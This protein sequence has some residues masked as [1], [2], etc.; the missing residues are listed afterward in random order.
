MNM[1]VDLRWEDER[2]DTIEEIYDSKNIFARLLDIN[3]SEMIC[4]R[5]IDRYGDT[6]FNQ[7]QIPVLIKELESIFE[8]TSTKQEK[9]ILRQII[10]LS[11]KSLGRVHT[12]LKFYGD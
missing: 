3:K 8:N 4:F 10:T 7:L 12:Y 1:G 6:I 11:K 5:F 2:G 9:D